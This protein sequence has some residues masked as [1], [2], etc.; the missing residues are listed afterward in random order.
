M[1]AEADAWAI[2]LVRRRFVHAMVRLPNG[3]WLVQHKPE[4]PVRLLTG[5]ADVLDLAAAVQHH[6]RT[7]R[8]DFR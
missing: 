5:P 8:P 7:T 2:V 6:L 1:A 4:E 3:Q